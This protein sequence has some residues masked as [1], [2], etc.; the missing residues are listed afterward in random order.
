L[1]KQLRKLTFPASPITIKLSR[2]AADAFD[3]Y[4]LGQFRTLDA[5]FGLQKKRGLPGYPKLRLKMA[6]IV[7][8]LKKAKKSKAQIQKELAH[9]GFKDTDWA[10]IKRVY[11]EWRVRL[12]SKDI[13]LDLD[14]GS[15]RMGAH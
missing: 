11:K 5:A 6:K 12:M 14:N 8:E 9:Q 4:L 2:Y 1:S 15:P 10:T 7:Y 13:H 3:G